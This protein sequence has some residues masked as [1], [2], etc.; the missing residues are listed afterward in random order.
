MAGVRGWRQ[1][2]PGCAAVRAAGAAHG[3]DQLE[4]A[5]GAGRVPGRHCQGEV[6]ISS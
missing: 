2:E 5:R 1:R 6:E 4:R 3:R